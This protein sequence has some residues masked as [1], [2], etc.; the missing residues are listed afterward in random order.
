MKNI[1]LISI[2]NLRYDCVGYQPFKREIEKYDALKFLETP[3]LDAF[4]EKGLCYTLCISTNPY[5][6]ASH[7]SI[8]TGLLPPNHGVRSFYDT[9]LSP[10][11]YTLAEALKMYGYRT[12]MS[13]DVM[14]LFVPL[15]LHRG[16]DHTFFLEDQK[17][18]QY[19]R[20]KRSDKNFI[21]VHFFDVHEPY[22]FSDFD[23]YPGYNTDYFEEIE[24]FSKLFGIPLGHTRGRPNAM[25]GELWKKVGRRDVEYLLPLFVKGVSKFDQGR[26]A[27]FFSQ[28][29]DI[30]CLDDALVVIFSDHG[31]GRISLK[32]PASF[33][34]AGELFD[35]VLRVPLLIQ[36][37]GVSPC[38]N[39]D[40]VS[41]TDIFS[42]ILST[43]TGRDA[44]EL[45][46]YE[47]DG[48]NLLGSQKRE[49]AYSEVWACRSPVFDFDREKEERFLG[50]FHL[51][52]SFILQRSFRMK[53]RKILLNGQPEV[54][55][56]PDIFSLSSEDFIKKLYRCLFVREED[57]EGL[58]SFL[59]E[60][61]RRGLNTKELYQ[62]FLDHAEYKSKPKMFSFDLEKDP[63]ED[64]PL[65]HQEIDLYGNDRWIHNI[66]EVE[67]KAVQTEMIFPENKGYRPPP[68]ASFSIL[69]ESP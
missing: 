60:L 8:F 10:D 14:E 16:F 53:N 18:L 24:R 27:W 63:F 22:L 3:H 11:V 35:N 23:V 34:H 69:E 21:F 26:F 44:G 56:N 30:G 61:G 49:I 68:E 19:L 46:P 7:A 40:L 9:K 52:S 62:V 48:I 15:D 17:F 50:K 59:W 54:F 1:V 5:T 33:L 65:V 6:T 45:F 67:S 66:I 25:W 2:D 41:L 12:M 32:D 28:M 43:V 64:Y 42:T 57:E 20:E 47:L 37:P 4:A 13:S 39:D 29:K 31:E 51:S 38:V 55:L 58:K 36:V